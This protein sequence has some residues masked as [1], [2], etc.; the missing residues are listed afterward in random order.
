[1]TINVAYCFDQ[2]NDLAHRSAFAN[3]PVV[4]AAAGDHRSGEICL[5]EKLLGVSYNARLYA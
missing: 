4:Q 5:S 3:I 1:M 2:N